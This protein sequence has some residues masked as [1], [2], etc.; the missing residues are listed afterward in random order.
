M[1][2]KAVAEVHKETRQLRSL[3][4][5]LQTT[6]EAIDARTR[7]PTQDIIELCSDVFTVLPAS[8]DTVWEWEKGE[9]PPRRRHEPAP[10]AHS[11]AGDSE[12]RRRRH[13]GHASLEITKLYLQLLED[14]VFVAPL[15]LLLR[16]AY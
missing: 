15:S 5:D 13:L 16:C 9:V 7:G 8:L 10:T 6:V 11:G 1:Q 12:H 3:V 4:E 2:A 14:D